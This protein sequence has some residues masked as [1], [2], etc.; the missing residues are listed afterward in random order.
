M[1]D[2]GHDTNIIGELTVAALAIMLKNKKPT[3]TQLF[4]ID[5]IRS[6][7]QDE[8]CFSLG[9]WSYS[10]AFKFEMLNSVVRDECMVLASI[11]P[12]FL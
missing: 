10:A 1:I 11:W 5:F 7:C 2:L 12:M 6:V 8:H 9:S 3:N 4:D